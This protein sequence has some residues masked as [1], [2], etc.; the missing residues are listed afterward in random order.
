MREASRIATAQKG[1]LQQTSGKSFSDK[2][3]DERRAWS[4][5]INDCPKHDLMYWLNQFEATSKIQGM[6]AASSCLPKP[7][8]SPGSKNAKVGPPCCLPSTVINRSS[9][10][11]A[12]SRIAL[13]PCKPRATSAS[14]VRSKRWARKPAVGAVSFSAKLGRLRVCR[15]RSKQWRA[16]CLACNTRRSL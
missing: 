6:P 5:S 14:A 4:N 8:M 3:L 7:P 12:A 15:R 9:T 1:S 16:A 2:T 13:L 10:S 11:K